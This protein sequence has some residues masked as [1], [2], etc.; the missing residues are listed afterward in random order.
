METKNNFWRTFRSFIIWFLVFYL[1]LS[2]FFQPKNNTNTDGILTLSALDDDVVLGNLA[3]FQL[4]NNTD[5]ALNFASPCEENSAESAVVS[6][7]VNGQ[8]LPLDIGKES[9]AGLESFPLSPGETKKITLHGWHNQTFTEAGRYDF[10]L[11]L[12]DENREISTVSTEVMYENPGFIRRFF[13]FIVTEPIFNTLVF[14]VDKLPGHSMGWAVI[15]LTL[16]VRIIFYLPNQHA[17]ESQRRLQKLQPRI[18]EIRKKCGKNKQMM[19]LQTMQLYRDEKI[20]PFSSIL[21]ILIQM[22]FLIGL[23]LV[24][25][26]G[27]APHLNHFLYSF[28]KNFDIT[29]VDNAFLGLD[30]SAAP[31]YASMQVLLP[32]IVAFAQFGAMKLAMYRSQ[33]QGDKKSGVPDDLAAQMQNAQKV[34]VYILPLMIG[35]FTITLPAAVGIYWL[36]STVFGMGQ[37]MLVNWRLDQPQLRVKK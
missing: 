11:Q 18:E 29:I 23:Y 19:A 8:K 16:L 31:Y 33:K 26:D 15:L 13:R 25:I 7:I 1:L 12:S 32:L 28:Q 4:K 9:C 3:N 10:T 20:N 2:F 36:A 34:M 14:F 37:Q 30:L 35:I 5:A 24:V 27:F 17:M 6:R 21:P 22:P